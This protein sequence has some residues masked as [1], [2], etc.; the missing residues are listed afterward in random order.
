[1]KLRFLVFVSLLCF[2]SVLFAQGGKVTGVLKDSVSG[3]PLKRAVVSLHTQQKKIDE[4]GRFEFIMIPYGDYDLIV[5][6]DGFERFSISV[7]VNKEEL[8]LGA[9]LTK[10]MKSDGADNSEGVVSVQDLEDEIG[11]AHV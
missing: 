1:M 3:E 11:R 10:G 6:A 9:I 8:D 7:S 2:S 4:N 5:E